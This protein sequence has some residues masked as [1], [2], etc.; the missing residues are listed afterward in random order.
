MKP[1]PA[2]ATYTGTGKLLVL[3]MGVHG[4]DLAR[5]RR[6]AGRPA[7]SRRRRSLPGMVAS[8]QGRAVRPRS[9]WRKWVGLPSLDHGRA[10]SAPKPRGKRPPSRSRGSSKSKTVENGRSGRQ[11]SI[12]L[13]DARVSARAAHARVKNHARSV[14]HEVA[15]DTNGAAGSASKLRARRENGALPLARASTRP[16]APRV[17]V[18]A[19]SAPQSSKHGGFRSEVRRCGRCRNA[20]HNAQTCGRG[21]A[22]MAPIRAVVK[23][24]ESGR[25]SRRPGGA[26]RGSH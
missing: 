3:P 26:D 5:E 13:Y 4:D 23:R 6:R 18:S 16:I 10:K 20:G 7:E 22:N 17:V 25:P 15:M 8:E 12:G 2:P 19:G 21:R 9:P 14:N 24:R 11:G 1:G